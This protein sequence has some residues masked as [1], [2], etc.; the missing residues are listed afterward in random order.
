MPALWKGDGH[1]LIGPVR[2]HRL[3]AIAT[4]VC[5]LVAG[6]LTPARALACGTDVG[7]DLSDGCLF[8]ITGSDTPNPADGFAVTNADDV[9]LWNFVRA[10]DLQAIGYPISQRWTDGPFTL[11]AFQKVI[12]QWD[13]DRERMNY[14]NTLDVLANRFPQIELSNVP[15]HQVL[16][17]D[18]GQDF[19]TVTRNHLTLL[20]SNPKIKARFLAEPD[21][22]NLY[23]L[24]IRYENREVHGNPIGLQVLRTQRTVFEIWNVPAPGTTPGNV[25]F[26]N[27]PDKVKRLDNVI[28]PNAAKD[29]LAT[30]APPPAIAST[31]DAP[32]GATLSAR[33]AQEIARVEWIQDGV[34][35]IEQ[36]AL[37]ELN[38]LGIVSED[39]LFHIFQ[40]IWVGGIHSPPTERDIR[41]LRTLVEIGGLP[42]IQDG[43][44]EDEHEAIQ[45]EYDLRTEGIRAIDGLDWVEDGVSHIDEIAIG[46]LERLLDH[47]SELLVHIV[48]HVWVDGIHTPPTEQNLANLELLVAIAEIPWIR[49]KLQEGNHDQFLAYFALGNG[50]A[51][52]FRQLLAKPWAQD[53]L[54]RDEEQVIG[55]LRTIALAQNE[56]PEDDHVGSVVQAIVE[57]PFLQSIEGHDPV[58]LR[59]LQDIRFR[60]Y[61]YFVHIVS[62]YQGR[63]GINDRDAQIV[64]VLDEIVDRDDSLLHRF[65]N[66][67]GVSL[68]NRTITLPRS[69]TMHIGIVRLRN[70]WSKTMEYLERAIRQTE[71]I[72]NEPFPSNY[73]ALLVADTVKPYGGWYYHGTHITMQD[74]Y[75]DPKHYFSRFTDQVLTHEV[76]HYYWHSCPSWLCEGGAVFV[77]IRAG[78]LGS[79]QRQDLAH[80]C[81]QTDIQSIASDHSTNCRYFLGAQLLHDLYF[82][83]GEELFQVGF[84]RLYRAT[85]GLEGPD[86]CD[87]MESGLCYLRYAFTQDTTPH[88][89]ATAWEFISRWYHGYSS[90][91]N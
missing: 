28:I 91:F 3:L 60:H 75:D 2:R 76:A 85:Q 83:L 1:P 86:S 46:H 14:Y 59:S 70:G 12:L 32:E 52:H 34:S 37:D 7:V 10:K 47:S 81:S 17:E 84:Q 45:A 20:D 53:G 21:W 19:A 30:Y 82:I 36:R 44:T 58:T 33:A 80:K 22:L 16:P 9:P 6:S 11:Q 15:P 87:G 72:M 54:V 39:F 49:S 67:D 38:T 65:L 90:R 61:H 48:R 56:G 55:Y 50:W 71:D 23:G 18:A 68:E 78:V 13:P 40:F 57:M 4:I 31:D 5:L 69:G 41:V 89:A 73:I 64:P 77:E 8:T 42:W 24:P 62:H 27:V 26:Q 29:P 74:G 88:A 63:G 25:Q 35:P 51:P 79:G 43:I 66:E